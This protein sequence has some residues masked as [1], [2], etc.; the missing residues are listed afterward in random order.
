MG[1]WKVRFPDLD[2]D[3]WEPIDAEAPVDA[4]AG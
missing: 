2:H 4:A 3:A 1:T